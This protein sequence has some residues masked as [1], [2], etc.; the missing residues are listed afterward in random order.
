MPD[1]ININPPHPNVAGVQMGADGMAV[2]ETAEI[3]QIA[4]TQDTLAPSDVSQVAQSQEVSECDSPH[5]AP[6][7]LNMLKAGNLDQ[8]RGNLWLNLGPLL[9]LRM[10]LREAYDLQMDISTREMGH[11]LQMRASIYQSSLQVAELASDIVL[12][13]AKELELDAWKSVGA[14]STAVIKGVVTIQN[15]GVAESGAAEYDQQIATKQEELAK[16]QQEQA[17][18]NNNPPQ[19]PVI[20]PPSGD[21]DM[22]ELN[23][24]AYEDDKQKYDAALAKYESEKNKKGMEVN[25]FQGEIDAL[26]QSRRTHVQQELH[27]RD[28]LTQAFGEA[29][30]HANNSTFD[31]IKADVKRELAQEELMQKTVEAN[32]QDMNKAEENAKKADQASE[33]AEKL[34]MDTINQLTQSAYQSH[35]LSNRA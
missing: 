34:L 31:F 14:G 15:V 24:I 17:N 16:A 6:P 8:D 23:R 26:K 1:S 18:L 5:I 19:Q 3:R 25:K 9:R 33:Q 27:H 12:T 20:P 32:V 11:A 35:S 22:D 4:P 21:A 7:N 13:Q 2:E 29:A 28:S 10:A 30:Q